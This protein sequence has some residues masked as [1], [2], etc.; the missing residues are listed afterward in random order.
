MEKQEL[1]EMVIS[2]S[3]EEAKKV[4]LVL[5]RM[6][7]DNYPLQSQELAELLVNAND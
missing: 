1:T 6:D 3:P 7:L 5:S 2:L 4:L